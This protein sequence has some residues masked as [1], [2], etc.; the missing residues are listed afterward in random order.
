MHAK[1]TKSRKRF[2][3][4]NTLC[5]EVLRNLPSLSARLVILIA[6]RHADIRACFRKSASEIGR[7]AGLS[8]RQVQRALTS[9]VEVGAIRVVSQERGSIPRVYQITGQPRTSNEDSKPLTGTK[10]I[11]NRGDTMSPR[12]NR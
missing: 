7:S 6:W 5:D 10:K 2:E 8:K 4:V 11:R 3:Q 1:K 12:A 9:L